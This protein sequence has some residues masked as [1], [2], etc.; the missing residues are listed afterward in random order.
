MIP[1]DN[2]ILIKN[3]QI[4]S[5]DRF[6]ENGYI[7]MKNKKIIEVGVLS[8][9]ENDQD[10]QIIEVPSGFIAVPGFID[11]HIHGVNGADTMDATKEALDTM[12]SALPKEGTTSFLATTITQERKEIEKA[13]INAGEYMKTQADQGK[14]EVLGIHLEGPFVNAKRAGAQP[15]HH[16]ID[17]NVSFLKEWLALSNHSIKLVTLAPEQPNGLEMVRYLKENGIIASI[18]H[19]DATYEQVVEAIEA[20]ANHVTHLFNQMKGLHHREPGVVGAAFLHD[21]LKAEIIADGVHVRPEMVKLAYQQKQREGLILITDSMR[22]KCLKNGTY[23]LGGQEVT[24]K[25][26]K[27]VL[28]DGTLAGSILKLGQAFKNILNYTGCS[29]EDAIQM[30]SVNPAKQLN[31]YDRKGSIAKGKDADIVILDHNREIFMTICRGE[32]AFHKEDDIK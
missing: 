20:G 4:Y 30:A 17:P 32:V 15:V 14:A 9:L 23:D 31:I 1:K 6:I 24:V 25:D 11:V 10:Y 22:A 12:A 3:I 18:G 26:G 2:L 8:D 16:I 19:S 5:E 7:I 27:A 21:E 13:L 28:E 29:I